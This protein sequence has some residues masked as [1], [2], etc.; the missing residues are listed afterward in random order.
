MVKI[1]TVSGDLIVKGALLL[2]AAALAVWAVRKAAGATSEVAGQAWDAA[3]DGAW[4]VTPW[5]NENIIYQTVNSNI[6]PDG[7]DTIGTALYGAVVRVEKWWDDATAPTGWHTGEGR[8]NNPS[9]YTAESTGVTPG[10]TG[11]GGA[12]FGMYPRQR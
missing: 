4:A 3:K 11:S 1:A 5:N 9:A 7:S 10:Y 12:A 6:F 2:G 8:W